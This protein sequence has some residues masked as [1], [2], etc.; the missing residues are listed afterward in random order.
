MSSEKKLSL[1]SKASEENSK[2]IAR[3][4]MRRSLSKIEASFATQ[5]TMTTKNIV[6]KSRKI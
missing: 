6:V 4:K 2:V 3:F 1:I 5:K